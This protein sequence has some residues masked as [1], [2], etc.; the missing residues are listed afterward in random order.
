MRNQC[1]TL[2][3]GKAVKHQRQHRRRAD[4]NKRARM[5]GQNIHRLRMVLMLHTNDNMGNLITFQPARRKTGANGIA[6]QQQG[7][8][9]Q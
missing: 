9:V 7:L 3:P 6:Q 8:S 4:L 2:L 5:S 1:E